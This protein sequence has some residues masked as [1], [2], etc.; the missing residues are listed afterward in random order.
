MQ[1]YKPTDICLI[2]EGSY[3]YVTGGVASWVQRLI[4]SYEGEFNF[5]VV[6][7][8]AG[9][10]AEEEFKYQLPANVVSFHSFDLFDYT[11]IKKASPVSFPKKTSIYQTLK[12]IMLEGFRRGYFMPEEVSLFKD[13]LTQHKERFFKHFLLSETGFQSLTEIYEQRH[14]HHGFLKYYYNWR[15]IHLV[16]WR[17]FMLL[18]ALPP[19]HVYH[20]PSA[21]F[22]GFLTCMM[23]ALY[24]KPSIITEHGI[25]IQEREME[26][27]V[28]QWLDEYYLR[29][30]WI[31]FFKAIT[32]WEYKTV[33]ELITLYH[34][35]KQL[36][37]E[38]GADP[39][40]IKIIPNGI[41][42]ERFIPARRE[43]LTSHPPVIGMVARVD[44]VKDVKTFIQVVANIKQVIPEIKAYV[45][46]PTEEYPDY[47]QECLALRNL[48]GL[49][50]T[51]IFTGPANV[52]EYYRQFDV[53]LLTS[54]KEAMP[55]VV[56]EAMASGLPVVTT[57]VGACEELVYGLNDGLG[58]A[59]LVATVMDAQ[60]LALKTLRILK[61]KDLANKMAEAG[62]KR[63]ERY[64]MEEKVK[65]AYRQIYLSCLDVSRCNR[66]I[67][68]SNALMMRGEGRANISGLTA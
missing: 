44:A 67:K 66:S 21:G 9:K 15:N 23:T 65:E 56:M 35:N 42:I 57:R 20:S 58:K 60:D 14:R 38:Y 37:I 32:F 39:D 7:L 49:D 30:M 19:A 4:K 5:A 46:G 6:A 18:N 47:Y 8:T 33:T 29:Q 43:R 27:N 34:G 61:N 55:L 28:A 1:K 17:V 22:A 50:D 41:N 40:K 10:K 3:P 31:D 2:V 45:V 64:Y 24:G 36:E 53:L 13:I 54:V 16:M 59:G 25:Y 51:I 63:I 12:N 62:I 11:S 68:I 52:V 48:L 26:L